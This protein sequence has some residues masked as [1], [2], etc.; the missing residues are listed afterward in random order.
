MRN[1]SSMSGILTAWLRLV[2]VL[3]VCGLSVSNGDG[4]FSKL[5]DLSSKIN[6]TSAGYAWVTAMGGDDLRSKG[7]VEEAF[8]ADDKVEQDTEVEPAF[9]SI[10][11]MLQ[12][13]IGHADPEKMK[14]SAQEVQ[15]MTPQELEKRR[16][17]IRDLMEKLRM[18]SD[19]DLMKVAIA[20]LHN[21][22]LPAEARKRALEELVILVEPID[23][24]NDLD[25]LGG[26]VVVI[27]ELDREEVELRAAAAAVLAMASQNNRIVQAQLLSYGVLPKLMKMARSPS[28][29]EA[30]KAFHAVSAIT[31][32]CPPGHEIFYRNGG[33]SLLTELLSSEN[34]DTR[35]RKKALFLVADLAEQ[36]VEVKGQLDAYNLDDGFL[37]SVVGQAE[38][39]DLDT[40]QKALDA[41]KSLHKVSKSVRE[42]LQN[43][44]HVEVVLGRLELYF[45][46]LIAEPDQERAEYIKDLEELRREVTELFASKEDESEAGERLKDD[47]ILYL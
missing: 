34:V 11:S 17:E 30:V 9:T 41:L 43:V 4:K 42:T 13:A 12:W 8:A 44:C 33:V 39:V 27:E 19:A 40:Q 5:A 24:A 21:E 28:S 29:E 46:K 3:L 32:N 35:L 47:Q 22:S 25:K 6:I 31:R 10:D 36:R 23:N 16:A 2:S 38:S 7:K 14:G 45:Q 20:D 1:R 18:P 15:R 26:L 37:R